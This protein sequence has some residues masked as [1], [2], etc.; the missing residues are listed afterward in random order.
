MNFRI[1]DL[2]KTSEQELLE[3][4][5]KNIMVAKMYRE[6]IARLKALSSSIQSKIEVEEKKEPHNLHQHQNKKTKTL[7]MKWTIILRQFIV[8]LLKN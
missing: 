7:K 1:L 5:D 3:C 2:N 6:E 4:I 8:L